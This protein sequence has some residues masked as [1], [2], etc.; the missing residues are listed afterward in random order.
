MFS[1][2]KRQKIKLAFLL[3]FLC[4]YWW[5]LPANLFKTKTSTVLLD[6]NNV[7]LAAQ[8]APDGQWRFPKSDSI[9]IKFEKCILTFEDEYFFYHPG[10]NPISI[11]NSFKRNL[12]ASKIKSGGSTITMQI[13]RMMRSNQTRNYYQKMVEVLLAL[14]IELSYKKSSILNIYCSNA[15]FG[16]NVVG[17]SA[18]SW[19]YFGRSPEKLSWAECA[20]L[21]VLPNA[22]SLIYPGKNQERLLNK[23]NRLLEKLYKKQIID[24]STYQLA[25]LEPLP[26]KPYPIPQTASHL[27]SYCISNQGQSK[28]F[29]STVNEKIQVRVN[30]LLNQHSQTLS[31][32]QINNACALVIETETGKVVAYVGNSYSSTNAHENYVD[33]IQAPR[34]T[35]SVL[36]PFLYAFML[37]ENKILPSSLIEDVPLRIGS[38]GPK[39]FNLSYDGLVNADKA[40]SR[41]LNVPAVK[42]LQEYGT[43]KF[44]QRLKQLGFTSFSKPTDHYG[45]SLILGGGEAKLW[46]IAGAYS[47]MARAL[48]HYSNS[49]NMYA[50]NSYHSLSYLK[51]NKQNNVVVK[52]KSDLLGASALY[53]TFKTMTE[54][55]R[56]QDY[57]GWAQF[58]SKKKIAW[59]TGT[60]FGFRD[61]WAVGLNGKYTVAVWVGNA[62]GEGRPDLTGT[63]SA[64]PLM[65]SIFNVLEQGKWFASP[66]SD[67]SKI[68]VCKQSGF[69]ASEVCDQT[70]WR[71]YPAGAQKTQVCPFHKL[72]HL[73]E[74][75]QHRVNSDCYPVNKMKHVAWFVISPIQEYYYKQHSLHYTSLP[76]FLSGCETE[77]NHRQMEIIYPREDFQIYI[78][79][80]QTG[81]KSRCV[82]KATHKDQ[83][84]I[85]FWHLDGEYIGSTEKF[86]ELSLT[87]QSG[88]HYLEITDKAGETQNCSFTVLKK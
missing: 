29:H 41:S 24:E 49:R 52:L 11:F 35:G 81:E 68:K 62:D 21:A 63:S 2:I 19:R 79:I 57:V 3:L 10:V 25:I 30:E 60:S 54:L 71:E 88:K 14:R 69:K 84:A 42:M 76:P 20:L 78:P 83:S 50:A 9:P 40:I 8:I 32:N 13:A 23:R 67:F 56:P 66:T 44:H 1:F 73:D 65:F 39:N 55:I 15:P 87:P 38:Y 82:L 6:Q 61:A 77:G 33:I 17:L 64:A 45:L 59:K 12:S 70:E 75:G 31:Q 34:S 18:A 4:I 72:I 26:N 37:N 36:K 85:L 46:E 53:F 47:S 86:H 5:W 16:G 80:D 28:I 74:S 48:M 58:L 43:Q 22:P 7:L 51:S 27:L